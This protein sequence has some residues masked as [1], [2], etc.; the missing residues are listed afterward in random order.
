MASIQCNEWN[1]PAT[2]GIVSGNNLVQKQLQI[3]RETPTSYATTENIVHD[4]HASHS[5]LTKPPTH[6]DNG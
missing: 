3:L 6:K 2:N 4:E 5:F 1:L